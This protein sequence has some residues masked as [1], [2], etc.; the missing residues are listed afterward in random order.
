MPVEIEVCPQ[1]YSI[2]FDRNIL[3]FLS[4]TA[5]CIYH[6]NGFLS[7]FHLNAYIAVIRLKGC[8]SCYVSVLHI[9]CLNGDIAGAC[10]AICSLGQCISCIQKTCR[11][12]CSC[13]TKISVSFCQRPEL[14]VRIM[15]PLPLQFQVGAV[16]IIFP[17]L[18]S[19]QIGKFLQ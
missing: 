14:I 12:I 4:F 9:G 10:R 3:D 13:Q 18:H 5:A 2:L 7:I 8:K 11:L 17:V 19:I 6:Y 15:I 16:V 1:I